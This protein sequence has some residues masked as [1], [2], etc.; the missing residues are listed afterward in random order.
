M[1]LDK[2]YLILKRTLVKNSIKIKK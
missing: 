2:V 1:N